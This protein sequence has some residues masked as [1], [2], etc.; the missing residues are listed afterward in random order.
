MA[1]MDDERLAKYLARAGVASRRAA[2]EL[3]AAGAVRVNGQIVS[4][5][6]TKVDPA[7][8]VVEV[9]GQRVQPATDH[10]TVAVHK[11]VGY[12]S[13]AHDPQGR[14]IAADLLPPDLRAR[15]LVPVGRLD[16]DSE[17]LLLLSDDGDLTLRLTHPRYGATKTY[18][19]Q[20]IDPVMPE[21]I[22]DLRQGIVL[23]GD[24]P[25]PTAPARVRR[26]SPPVALADGTVG[27]WYEVTLREGRKRQV[28][29]MF[30]AVGARVARLIRLRVGRLDLVAVAP[31]PGDW[32][33]LT[34]DEIALALAGSG[35]GP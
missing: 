11:P 29:L 1:L 22:D 6:G 33:T 15:R 10:L 16:A 20:V 14:P 24:D 21:D 4:E 5:Q 3:I 2:E 28:R 25:R 18:L 32:H 27:Q 35:K 26:T 34:A 31:F 7:H 17:G 19:A 23:A 12:V 13:T 30:A 8:D 9:N